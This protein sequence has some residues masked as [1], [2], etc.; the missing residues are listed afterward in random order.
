VAARSGRQ[1]P[2]D[3]DLAMARL[4]VV[5]WRGKEPIAVDRGP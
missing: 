4:G 3:R 1:Q 5:T 2:G